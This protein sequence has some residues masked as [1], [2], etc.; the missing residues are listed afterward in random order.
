MINQHVREAIAG[1]MTCDITTIGRRS[2]APRRIEIW[3]FVAPRWTDDEPAGASQGGSTGDRAAAPLDGSAVYITGTP[4]PRDWLANVR[5][6]PRMTFHV[7]EGAHADLPAIATEITDPEQRR[8]L[9]MHIRDT[10]Q[11]YV[12]QGHSLDAWIAGSPLIRVDLTA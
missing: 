10:E 9:M 8:R 3:Y 4:G 1:G 2:H 6:D 7:K 11:W 5:A 12:D